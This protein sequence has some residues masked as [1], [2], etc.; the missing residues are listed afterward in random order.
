MIECFALEN[1]INL[2]NKIF[3]KYYEKALK[4]KDKLSKL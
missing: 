1:T 2:N 4:I 3:K